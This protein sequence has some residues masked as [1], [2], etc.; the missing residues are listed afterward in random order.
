MFGVFNVQK[1]V[2]VCFMQS[3]LK[4]SQKKNLLKCQRI[5]DAHNFYENLQDFV[6]LQ[7]FVLI[8]KSFHLKETKFQ[9]FE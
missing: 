1:A 3:C 6:W 4:N 7:F 2:Q 9:D 5:A 8:F